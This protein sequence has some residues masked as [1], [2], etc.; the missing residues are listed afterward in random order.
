MRWIECKTGGVTKRVLMVKD[1]IGIGRA[2]TCEFSFPDDREVSRIHA[3]IEQRG[4]HWFVVDQKST[5]GSYV[6]SQR[7]TVPFPLKEDDVIEIGEQR[8]HVKSG[9][10][11]TVKDSVDTTHAGCPHLYV[12]LKVNRNSSLEEIDRAYSALAKIFDP[13]LHPGDEMAL[14]LT[15]E[16]EEA[17]RT[18]SD[19]DRRAAYDATLHS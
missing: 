14:R 9:L 19:P 7:V 11:F 4:E 3:I 2:A 13:N 10:D 15:K 6:N 17:Y 12:I 5:N 18:L 1:P 8:L 16:L